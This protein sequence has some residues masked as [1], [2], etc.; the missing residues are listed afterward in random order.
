MLQCQRNK[1]LQQSTPCSSMTSLTNLLSSA[2]LFRPLRQQ[3]SRV[4][5]SNCFLVGGRIVFTGF[6]WIHSELNSFFKVNIRIGMGLISGTNLG[7]T[8]RQRTQKTFIIEQNQKKRRDQNSGRKSG[9]E[10]GSFVNGKSQESIRCKYLKPYIM[11]T[12]VVTIQL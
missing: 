2:S 9:A 6:V 1:T 4:S 5:R 12:L 8:R 10:T 7:H 11:Y 3:F